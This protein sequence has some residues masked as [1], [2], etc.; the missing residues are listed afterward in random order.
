[1]KRERKIYDATFK[2]KV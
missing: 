1:M 2:I